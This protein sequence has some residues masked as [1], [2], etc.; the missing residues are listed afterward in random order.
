MKDGIN[1]YIVHGQRN[2][3]NPE[4]RGTKV[5]AHY[6][7]TLGPGESQTV[8]LSILPP[9]SPNTEPRTYDVV[10]V[11][12][13]QEN[14][15]QE[16]H[17]RLALTVNPYRQFTSLMDPQRFRSGRSSLVRVFNQG[18][19]PETYFIFWKDCKW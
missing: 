14:G 1:N 18:N 3:V 6:S 16:Q 2:A 11:A 17:Q 15:I 7:L 4:G 5:S 13:C 19:S 9:R 12:T 8:T 10:V